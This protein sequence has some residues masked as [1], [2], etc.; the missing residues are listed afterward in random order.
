MV[1]PHPLDQPVARH[2]LV[3][4]KKKD[5]EKGALLRPAE[6]ETPPVA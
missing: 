2:R 5:R 1:A 4:V 3:R 6:S